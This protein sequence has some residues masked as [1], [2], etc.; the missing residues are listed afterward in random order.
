MTWYS[1]F[2]S[3]AQYF[4]GSKERWA[5]RRVKNTLKS[6]KEKVSQ[7]V[8]EAKKDPVYM[9]DKGVQNFL[10]LASATYSV[11]FVVVQNTEEEPPLLNLQPSHGLHKW[12]TSIVAAILFFRC[13]IVQV[14]L[15]DRDI[16][17]E[18]GHLSSY[19]GIYIMFAVCSV[20]LMGDILTILSFGQEITGFYNA[21][22]GFSRS[23]SRTLSL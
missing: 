18:N 12:L 23:F 16:W 7:F 15:L 9:W 11:P 20:G 5:P 4:S 1:S 14:T 21:V 10:S 8:Q 17:V 3:V 13:A 6:W 22:H 2:H 19:A